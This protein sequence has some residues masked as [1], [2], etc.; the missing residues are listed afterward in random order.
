MNKLISANLYRLK[1]NKTFYA[2]IAIYFVY[3]LYITTEFI[4]AE[5]GGFPRDVG[6][7]LYI[8]FTPTQYIMFFPLVVGVIC[9]LFITEDFQSG[10]ARNKVIVGRTK[11][12]IYL[13]NFITTMFICMFYYTIYLILSFTI[14]GLLLGYGTEGETIEFSKTIIVSYGIVISYSAVI[15]FISMIIKNSTF[16]VIATVVIFVLTAGVAINLVYKL[17]LPDTYIAS[18]WENGALVEKEVEN[19]MQLSPKM[20][21]LARFFTKLIPSGQVNYLLSTNYPL[22]ETVNGVSWI[23]LLY[24]GLVVTVTNLVG[25]FIF[26]KTDIK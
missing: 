15:A 9:S 23:M 12:Q 2:G 14:G 18:I 4:T 20:N 13:S 6:D 7:L 26:K 16:S 10:A 25:L 5:K 24:S 11:P 21:E 22:S 19:F 3:F 8:A 1:K 17:D